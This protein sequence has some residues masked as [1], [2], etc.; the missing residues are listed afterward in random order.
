M[1]YLYSFDKK[2]VIET[3]NKSAGYDLSKVVSA[4]RKT[5]PVEEGSLDIAFFESCTGV[6]AITDAAVLYTKRR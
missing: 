4:V 3:D 1:F 6:G 5:T 2:D